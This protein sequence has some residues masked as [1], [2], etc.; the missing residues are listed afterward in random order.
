MPRRLSLTPHLSVEELEQRYH[1][2]RLPVERTHWH[3]LWLMAQGHG[4]PEA[5]RLVGYTDDWA[6][7]LIHRYNAE[8]PAG[9]VDRRHANPGQPPLLD[10]VAREALRQA[11]TGPAPDGGLWTGRKVAAWMSERLARPIGEVRGWEAMRLLG[12]TPQ[13]PRPQATTADPAAQAAFKK[14]G[15]GTS[16]LR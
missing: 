12:F 4:V 5:A 13:R 3:L 14:G 15:F 7:T 8:G 11:L 10:G 2:C 1:S 16:S 6:R 9:V